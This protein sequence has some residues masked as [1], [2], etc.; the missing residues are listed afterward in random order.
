[1]YEEYS[2]FS[3][4]RFRWNVF[5]Q[6]K[7]S[8][9]FKAEN[10]EEIRIKPSQI[11]VCQPKTGKTQVKEINPKDYIMWMENMFVFKGQT[12]ERILSEVSIWY[13][14]QIDIQVDVKDM[15]LTLITNKDNSLE[16]ILKFITKITN[17]KITK[18]GDMEYKTE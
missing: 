9:G 11:V 2:D 13:G 10:Q 8:I 5:K 18:T 6:S 14:V 7:G 17:I 12:L 16:D 1:M 3:C 4:D 15:K